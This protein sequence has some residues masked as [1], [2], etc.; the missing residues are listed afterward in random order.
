MVAPDAIRLSI[1]S[2]RSVV[3][4]SRAESV[5]VA[6]PPTASVPTGAHTLLGLY[7][8]TSEGPRDLVDALRFGTHSLLTHRGGLTQKSLG[9][10]TGIPL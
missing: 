10:P 9:G 7:P 6:Q 5:A 2:V 1:P 8:Q 4:E 3:V